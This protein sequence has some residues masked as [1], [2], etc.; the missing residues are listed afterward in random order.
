MSAFLCSE[1]HYAS[2]AKTF[3][4]V[5][6]PMP[7]GRLP[8]QTDDGEIDFAEVIMRDPVAAMNLLIGQNATSVAYRYNERVPAFKITI[9]DVDRAPALPLDGLRTALACVG[10]QSCEHPEWDADGWDAALHAIEALLPE[11]AR[12]DRSNYWGID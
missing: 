6:V 11:Q 12:N 3:A 8:V 7:D 5:N 1:R 10:Y 4:T 2:I 9:A